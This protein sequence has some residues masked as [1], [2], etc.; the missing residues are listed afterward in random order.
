MNLTTDIKESLGRKRLT[1]KDLKKWKAYTGLKASR[2]RLNLFQSA[3][4]QTK[5]MNLRSETEFKKWVGFSDRTEGTLEEILNWG[6]NP[7]FILWTVLRVELLP[8]DYIHHLALFFCRNFHERLAKEGV[9]IDFRY[10]PI[11]QIKEAW[12]NGALSLG[13]LN[14]QKRNCS[15]MLVDVHA[16]KDEKMIAAAAALHAI[17][18]EDPRAAILDVF[19]IINGV[20]ASKEENVFRLKTLKW[21]I[22]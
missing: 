8:P 6:I 4:E 9:Y 10:K 13:N 1:Y 21:H 17:L 22:I 19:G 7:H 2:K 15:Q 20:Y 14:H 3:Q 16:S 12:T 5:L 18:N 11:L